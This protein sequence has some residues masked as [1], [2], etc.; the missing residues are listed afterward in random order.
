MVTAFVK[1]DEDESGSVE[2]EES[3]KYFGGQRTKFTERLFYVDSKGERDARGLEF[4]AW[5]IEVW[6]FCTLD[7]SQLGRYAFEIMDVDVKCVLEKADIETLYRMLYDCDEA[8]PYFIGQVP[9]DNAQCIT[10]DAFV[11]FS[12]RNHHIIQPMITY[13]RRLRRRIGS[14]S[15]WE[16]LG[17]YRR[18]YFQAVDS[19]SATLAIAAEAVVAMEDPARKRKQQIAEAL[20]REQTAKLELEAEMHEK[21]LRQ[22]ERQLAKERKMAAR[23][24]ELSKMKK[25][26]NAYQARRKEFDNAQFTVDNVWE[27]RELRLNLFTLLDEWNEASVIYWAKSDKT[28]IEHTM[29]TDADHDMRYLDFLATPVRQLIA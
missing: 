25:T 16:G 29:G 20:L 17:G 26:W 24:A 2:Q 15:M 19:G 1:I 27:R 12:K 11:A 23:S 9:F 3:L 28:T 6:S 10:K 13:Q 18:R 8:D 4:R 22:H 5:A 7:Y 14:V 21:E